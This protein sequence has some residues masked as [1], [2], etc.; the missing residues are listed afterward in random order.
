LKR[1]GVVYDSATGVRQCEVEL[2]DEATIEAALQ[3]AKSIFVTVDPDWEHA[4]AGVYGRVLGCAHVWDDG[5]RIEVYRSL[6][7]DPRARR[8]QRAAKSSKTNRNR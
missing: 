3:V 5:D 7:L 2:P 1:C 4:A 6:Q 8:R